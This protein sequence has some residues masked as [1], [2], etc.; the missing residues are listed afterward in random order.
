MTATETTRVAQADISLPLQPVGPPF[1]GDPDRSLSPRVLLGPGLMRSPQYLLMQAYPLVK[2][3]PLFLELREDIH[4]AGFSPFRAL[5][6]L[7]I[8]A[9]SLFLAMQH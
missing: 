8:L 7:D 3:A 2:E 4:S 5:A 6:Y 9:E 1:S